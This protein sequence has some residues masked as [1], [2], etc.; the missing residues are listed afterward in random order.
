MQ[1][2]VDWQ[3]T[4]NSLTYKLSDAAAADVV[5]MLAG[6][7]PTAAEQGVLHCLSMS[8]RLTGRSAVQVLELPDRQLMHRLIAQTAAQPGELDVVR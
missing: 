4:D 6:P 1:T 8:S 7:V 3:Q 2:A 5:L